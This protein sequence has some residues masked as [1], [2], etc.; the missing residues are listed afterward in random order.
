MAPVSSARG[1][2]PVTLAQ[3][4]V[5]QVL[6]TTKFLV[7]GMLEQTTEFFHLNQ[8][9]DNV[10]ASLRS[11]LTPVAPQLETSTPVRAAVTSH[12]PQRTSVPW[13]IKGFS[14]ETGPASLDRRLSIRQVEASLSQKPDHPRSLNTPR[15]NITAGH[16]IRAVKPAGGHQ[17][18]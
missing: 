12:L 8:N 3:T 9:R 7:T 4:P 10:A 16:M 17:H 13:K 14:S 6:E 18:L 15:I 1:V 11:S 2:L 5:G